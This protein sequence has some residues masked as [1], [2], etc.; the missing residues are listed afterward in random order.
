MSISLLG[1]K[2]PS[3]SLEPTA[4]ALLRFAEFLVAQLG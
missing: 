2:A 4:A 1:H 3:Q